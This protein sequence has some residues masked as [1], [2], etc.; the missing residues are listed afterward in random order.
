MRPALTPPPRRARPSAPT[1]RRAATVLSLAAVMTVVAACGAT[2]SAPVD[3][4]GRTVPR[5]VP[6]ADRSTGSEGATALAA[7]RAFRVDIGNA[8][9]AFVSDIG[10]LQRDL[11]ADD[12]PAART[13]ELGA[14]AQFDQFRQLAG[15]NPI[16]A[17]TVDELASQVG[18]GQSFGGLHAVERDLWATPGGEISQAVADASGLEAQAPVAEYLLSRDAPA[19][20]A[21]GALGVDDLNWLDDE[22]VT[23]DQELYSHLDA[24]DIAASATAADTAFAAIAPLAQQVAPTLSSEVAGRFTTLTSEVKSLGPPT[25]V[26]DSQLAAPRLLAISQQA[27]ATAAGLAQLAADLAPFGTGGGGDP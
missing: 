3:G 6:V 8:S 23:E 5:S 18:P 26:A 10:D 13:D 15:G 9:S 17:S 14:Q 16:N 7:V 24:V 4:G 12:V 21:I 2:A 20:E 11:A 22:A 19:P 25:Q 1:V 27:D